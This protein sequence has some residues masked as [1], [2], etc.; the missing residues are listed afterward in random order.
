MHGLKPCA[1]CL[2]LNFSNNTE[3]HLLLCSL[4][5]IWGSHWS[6]VIGHMVSYFFPSNLANGSVTAADWLGYFRSSVLWAS[7]GAGHQAPRKVKKGVLLISHLWRWFS[8]GGGGLFP[9]GTPGCLALCH[10]LLYADAQGGPCFTPRRTGA[11]DTDGLLQSQSAAESSILSPICSA[12]VQPAAPE[13]KTTEPHIIL[14]FPHIPSLC[15]I[16]VNY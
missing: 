14:L 15:A 11:R 16:N 12:P 8:G 2:I 3:D 10:N 9:V 4:T 5:W 7:P 13:Q 6:F 1:T